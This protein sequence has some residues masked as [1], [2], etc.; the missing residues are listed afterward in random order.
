MKFLSLSYKI[1]GN[2]APW[3][4]NPDSCPDVPFQ[5]YLFKRWHLPSAFEWPGRSGED[6]KDMPSLI[7]SMVIPIYKEVEKWV[8]FFFCCLFLSSHFPS[9]LKGSITERE[10]KRIWGKRTMSPYVILVVEMDSCLLL[11]HMAFSLWWPTK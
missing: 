6:D 10:R 4:R 1:L 2:C 8:S 11:Y 5:L 7:S 9:V 3:V